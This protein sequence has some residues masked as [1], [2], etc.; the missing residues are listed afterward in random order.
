[1]NLC[2]ALYTKDTGSQRNTEKDSGVEPSTAFLEWPSNQK[3]FLNRTA[4]ARSCKFV[5]RIPPLTPVP[6]KQSPSAERRFDIAC[7]FKQM[8]LKSRKGQDKK[9]PSLTYTVQLFFS[10]AIIHGTAIFVNSKIARVPR[11][12]I[13][14]EAHDRRTHH[15]LLTIL[16]ISYIFRALHN[17]SNNSMEC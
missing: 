16:Q 3:S 12:K 5:F 7:L 13:N 2:A 6:F 1:V 4:R 11:S 8:Y 14:G 15:V 10:I 17:G 9:E